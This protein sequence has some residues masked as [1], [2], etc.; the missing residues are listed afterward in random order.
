MDNPSRLD[1]DLDRPSYLPGDVAKVQIKAP[2]SG[3]LF[4]TIER[5]RVLSHRTVMM[6]EN[7][8]VIDI[9]ITTDF[10]PNVYVSAS[11]VR[12]AQSLERHAPARA[13]GIVPIKIDAHKNRL[14][15]ELKTPKLIRPNTELEIDYYV[16]GESGKSHLT[17]AAV[18]EGILQL[19]DFKTP[20]AHQHFFRQRGL[21]IQSHDSYSAILPEIKITKGKSSTGGDGVDAGR[22]RRLSTVSVSRVK[23]VAMW[24]GIIET[25]QFGKGSVKFSVPQFNGS[26]RIMAVTF[27]NDRFGFDSEM[28]TI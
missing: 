4:L 28:V 12:S 11:L 18:D 19:T 7:T 14:Q 20:D 5:D 2:F 22:K 1:I 21:G 17:V 23:P 15:V 3:K 6:K 9:P 27:S 10:R 25:D 13:F 16:T 26:L 24:S 8:G